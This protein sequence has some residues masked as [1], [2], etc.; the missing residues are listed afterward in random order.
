MGGK[1]SSLGRD[2]IVLVTK[3]LHSTVKL[4]VEYQFL[5][6]SQFYEYLMM[7]KSGVCFVR[8]GCITQC[9]QTQNGGHHRKPGKVS[10][11]RLAIIP[12]SG[13][14]PYG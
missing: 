5:V 1:R 8:G 6:T 12:I 7:L 4:M 10:E 3:N 13:I 2:K 11:I 14:K 9:K